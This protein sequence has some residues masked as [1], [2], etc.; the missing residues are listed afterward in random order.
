MLISSATDLTTTGP[1]IAF[2]SV[3]AGSLGVPIPNFA[4]IIFVGSLLATRHGSVETGAVVFA[5]AMAGAVLGDVA[6]F[7]AGRRYGTRVLSLICRLS[8]SRDSCV[9]RMT[10]AFRRRGVRV[11]LFARFLPGLSVLSAPLAGISG[12]SLARFVI[13]AETGAAIWIGAGLALGLAFAE[14]VGAMLLTIGHFGVGLGG[15]AVAMIL[16]YAGF[17]WFRRQRL[18]HRLRIARISP[19]ELAALMAAGSAPVI[20]DARSA[21]EQDANPF[22][23]PGALLFQY[24]PFN[25]DALRASRLQ[26]VV[27]YCSCPNE[28]SAA[29]LA[30]RMRELGFADVRPLLGGIDAWR[31]AGHPVLPIAP[32]GQATAIDLAIFDLMQMPTTLPSS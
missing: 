9:R 18:L 28:I 21:F 22:I 8:L 24:R 16:A 5:A 30:Q 1:L 19:D 11:S 14:Q 10:D 26:P 2:V 13:Y 23:I 17:S 4:A 6:W 32:P 29:V 25:Q 15:L 27:I 31:E 7:F 3:L 20:I 12:V